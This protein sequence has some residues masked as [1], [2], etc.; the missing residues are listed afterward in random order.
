METGSHEGK[1]R[2]DFIDP[3][4]EVWYINPE[5]IS[6]NRH[7]IETSSAQKF[8]LNFKDEPF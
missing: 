1:P 8:T 2:V 7:I 4:L 6:S 5:R 3:S